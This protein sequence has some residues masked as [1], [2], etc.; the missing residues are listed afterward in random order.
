MLEALPRDFSTVD[1]KA[2]M[3]IESRG[4]R[5][6]PAE[7]RIRDFDEAII[8]L[9]EE[10]AQHE[11]S[12]C[13]HCPDPAPCHKACPQDA[14]RSGS[15]ERKYC[16][17]ENDKRY[18]NEELLPGEIMGI[19]EPSMVMKTCRACEFA[20]PVAQKKNTWLNVEMI[21]VGAVDR[22]IS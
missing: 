16:K 2:R 10:W 11:A 5:L 4:L 20:C 18:A 17:I 3:K 12:R 6:R 21:E 14:F 19:D 9:D 8:R 7:E 22:L 13:I 1:R 15:F